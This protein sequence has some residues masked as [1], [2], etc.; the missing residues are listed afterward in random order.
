MTVTRTL[1]FH[2][3][4]PRPDLADAVGSEVVRVLDE[5][6]IVKNWKRNAKGSRVDVRA[7][8][9]NEAEVQVLA[10]KARTAASYITVL[11]YEVGVR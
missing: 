7:T 2:L 9:G 11:D 6:V 8:F 4:Y 5:H 10:D 1:M 3:Y